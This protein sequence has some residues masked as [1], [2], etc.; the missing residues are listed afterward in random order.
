MKFVIA[1]DSFKE[2][3][4]AAEAAAAI[5]L[6]IRKVAPDAECV[7]VPMSDGGEGFTSAV[8]TAWGATPVVIDSVDALGRELRA[9]YA[10]SGNRAVLEMAA[11]AGLEQIEP[12]KRDV[13][14]STTVGL[15]LMIKDA[16]ERGANQLLIGIGGSATNDA[17][18]GMLAAL[19]ARL[20]DSAGNEVNPFPMELSRVA[21]IDTTE[22]D[23]LLAGVEVLVASDVTN[24]L[25]G[26]N[27]AT[28]V[29]GP[30]KGV[31]RTMLPPLDHALGAFATAAGKLDLAERPGAGAAGGLGFALTAYLGGKLRPGVELVAEAVG[32]AAKL[33][34]ADL[35]F[36]GEGSVDEQTLGGKTPAGVAA[37]AQRVGVPCVVLAGRVKPGAEVLLQH[38]VTELVQIVASDV[39]LPEALAGG[40]VNLAVAA[41]NVVERYLDAEN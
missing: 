33:Q 29:F 28:V 34:D 1:P 41:S 14:S 12:E 17:G 11:T 40:P 37:A 31:T 24:P 39:P 35:A 23:E 25:C 16:I 4:T 21:T 32:L 7:E 15:G 19:G 13:L 26:P 6:G 9:E 10:M 2:S 30:Q 20:L 8:A 27:G 18:A 38:G 3:M 22:L 5:A 36:T